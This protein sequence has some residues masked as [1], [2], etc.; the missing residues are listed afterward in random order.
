MATKKQK[1]ERI[2]LKREKFEADVRESG[3]RAQRSD[4]KHRE[5]QKDAKPQGDRPGEAKATGLT[6]KAGG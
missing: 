5:A 3:L 1:R 6:R 2:R 4:R